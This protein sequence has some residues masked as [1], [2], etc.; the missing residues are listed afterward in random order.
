MTWLKINH[1]IPKIVS[2]AAMKSKAWMCWV[3]RFK[4]ICAPVFP[5]NSS[6]P[7][8]PCSFK[9]RAVTFWFQCKRRCGRYSWLLDLT[10]L[11]K[12]SS[13]SCWELKVD[14]SCKDLNQAAIRRVRCENSIWVCNIVES[15][16]YAIQT[17]SRQ[18]QLS[19]SPLRLFPFV[20][21]IHSNAKLC[22]GRMPI[23]NMIT[24]DIKK[25]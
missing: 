13:P 8:H 9:R 14:T 6:H 3:P 10:N 18:H 2:N 20:S 21:R 11:F 24:I 5:D 17:Q 19:S 4:C 22:F 25:S 7:C 1:K 16:Y 23:T 12:I 15:G